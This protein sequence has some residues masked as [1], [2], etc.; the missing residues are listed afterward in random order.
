MDDDVD[1]NDRGKGDDEEKNDD[2]LEELSN[3]MIVNL[4]SRWIRRQRSRSSISDFAKECST[5][6]NFGIGGAE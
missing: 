3:T 6:S 1:D 2:D 5:S 4:R